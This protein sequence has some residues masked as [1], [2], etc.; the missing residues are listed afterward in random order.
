MGGAISQNEAYRVSVNLHFLKI[1]ATPLSS[2]YNTW[3]RDKICSELHK[4]TKNYHLLL[5]LPMPFIPGDNQS[6]GG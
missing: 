6:T 2:Y 1:P 3:N 4:E 5:G